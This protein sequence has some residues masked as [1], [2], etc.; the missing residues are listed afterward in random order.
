MAEHFWSECSLHNNSG[1]VWPFQKNQLFV[2]TIIS[3][4]PG[5]VWLTKATNSEPW[6]EFIKPQSPGSTVFT[7]PVALPP[8][9]WTLGQYPSII[10][11]NHCPSFQL[12]PIVSEFARSGGRRAFTAVLKFLDTQPK[13][14]TKPWLGCGFEA[15]TPKLCLQQ[16]NLKKLISG[17]ASGDIQS[18]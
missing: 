3:K 4:N 13:T 6:F 18:A 11:A 12:W 2:K 10:V 17:I 8:I 5:T 1:P 9:F 15:G 14:L 16:D 7:C